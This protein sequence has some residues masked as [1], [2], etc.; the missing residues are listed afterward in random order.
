MSTRYWSCLSFLLALW[1]LSASP[2]H[3]SWRIQK[4]R[5]SPDPASV[6][7]FDIQ[8]ETTDAVSSWV[9]FHE[10][11][12]PSGEVVTPMIAATTRH[13]IPIWGLK[14]DTDYYFRIHTW[15]DDGTGTSVEQVWGPDVITTDPLPED[16]IQI[17]VT[18]S[19]S[20]DTEYLLVEANCDGYD[21]LAIVDHE[22]E[23][24]W[25]QEL[26]GKLDGYTFTDSN[27]VMAI[28]DLESIYEYDLQGHVLRA[29]HQTGDGGPL[30]K[31][32]H[33]EVFKYD[34]QIWVLTAEL[35]TYDGADYVADGIQ[36]YDD[37]GTLAL[38]WNFT[39]VMPDPTAYPTSGHSSSF[40]KGHYGSATDWTHAN[41]IDIDDDD[42]WLVS[43]RHTNHVLKVNSAGMDD[44]DPNYGQI[45]WMLGD[46]GD[47]TFGSGSL[48]TDWF[49]KQHHARRTDEGTLLLYDNAN[50]RGTAR[51]LEFDIDTSAYT[52][53]VV[54]EQSLGMT[55]NA[56]GGVWITEND[57]YLT[58]CGPEATVLEFDT[59][60][61][62]V[63]RL[64]AD[65]PTT[66]PSC[67]ELTIYRAIP[68]YDIY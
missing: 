36:I 32:V 18:A 49:D 10:V 54:V 39:D 47:F 48:S 38:E 1:A 65:C 50:S 16:F 17:S 2:A 8:F 27:T 24:R 67:S 63:W 26:P 62:E 64:E 7:R 14:P 19:G 4:L 52:A 51:I 60:G 15:G 58:N 21:A 9:S 33:H 41:S 45:E 11:G 29:W 53:E 34:G 57:H 40:W 46:S 13:S 61:S 20:Y 5:I 37:D 42:N 25:Y 22:G 6:L 3:A 55:C 35:Y 28:V 59:S 30:T 43:F 31:P 23:V 44:T 56:Q 68:V 66:S 12:D